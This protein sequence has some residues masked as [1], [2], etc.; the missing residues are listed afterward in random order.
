METKTQL[1][2][3]DKIVESHYGSLKLHTIDRVTAKRAYAKD[4][5]LDRIISPEQLLAN[6]TLKQIG[7]NT[8][9]STSYSYY[10]HEK[11]NDRIVR[12][13]LLSKATIL[14]NNIK[15]SKLPN[16]TLEKLIELL[17]PQQ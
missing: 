4:I 2:V 6:W 12:G 11:H 7:G 14:V 17:K 1:E 8:W 13:E 15:V 3:G 16:E 5:Q 10:V 9:A